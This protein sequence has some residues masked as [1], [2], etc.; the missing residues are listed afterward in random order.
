M[1]KEDSDKQTEAEKADKRE[2]PNYEKKIIDIFK[3]LLGIN[4]HKYGAKAKSL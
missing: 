4:Y 2:V 1:K 3:L